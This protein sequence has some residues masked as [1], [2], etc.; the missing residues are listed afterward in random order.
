MMPMIECLTCP[1]CKKPFLRTDQIVKRM[2]MTIKIRG[3]TVCEDCNDKMVGAM[4]NGA[5]GFWCTWDEGWR[6]IE[7]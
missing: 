3:G 6:S 1:T 7:E 4:L 5:Q 2:G